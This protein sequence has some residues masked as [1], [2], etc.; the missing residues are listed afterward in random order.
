MM[1]ACHSC[2]AACTSPAP[3]VF[4]RLPAHPTSAFGS[5]IVSFTLC[6]AA[7]RCQLLIVK[8]EEGY[9]DAGPG[10]C[11]GAGPVGC[12]RKRVILDETTLGL[13]A[14]PAA[15]EW[16]DGRPSVKEMHRRITE[17]LQ[18]RGM[19]GGGGQTPCSASVC[20]LSCSPGMAG[21]RI[22]RLGPRGR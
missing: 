11:G 7:Q 10:S 3:A 21:A 5:H 22:G 4:L 18:V 20:M 1:R 12:K 15:H 9:A 2:F 17:Y 8:V 6:A 16:H 14:V 13:W 19:C